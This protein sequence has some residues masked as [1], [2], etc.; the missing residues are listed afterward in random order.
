MS[1]H[2]ERS[3]TDEDLIH[4]KLE[5]AQIR[6]R[7]DSTRLQARQLI[8]QRKTLRETAKKIS[9]ETE[10]QQLILVEKMAVI[11]KLKQEVV[12]AEE[13]RERLLARLGRKKTGEGETGGDD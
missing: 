12:R 6:A 8:S 3:A 4:L 5:L 7:T 11:N 13:E 10:E 1:H 2:S 9:A